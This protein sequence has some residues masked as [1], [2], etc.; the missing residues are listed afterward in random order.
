M[1]LLFLP[2]T[3]TYRCYYARARYEEGDGLLSR[4]HAHPVKHRDVQ[5]QRSEIPAS[6]EDEERADFNFWLVLR[7]TSDYQVGRRLRISFLMLFAQQFLGINMLVYCSAQVF[8]GL[9]YDERTYCE[10][11]GGFAAS[12]GP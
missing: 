3:P 10:H 8:L 6:I 4:R 11:L 9:G 2:D 12:N 5:L 7:D 1:G